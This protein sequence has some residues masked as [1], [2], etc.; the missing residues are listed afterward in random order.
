MACRVEEAAITAGWR[1][2]SDLVPDSTY[3]RVGRWRCAQLF[4]IRS[5]N[6]R[7]RR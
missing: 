5:K 6:C 3:G 1:D 2:A 4:A 7:I